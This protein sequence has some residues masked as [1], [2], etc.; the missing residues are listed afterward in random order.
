MKWYNEPR[1]KLIST[2]FWQK[3]KINGPKDQGKLS[4]AT[5]LMFTRLA[6]PKKGNK[7]LNDIKDKGYTKND[8]SKEIRDIY[9]FQSFTDTMK[10]LVKYNIP[11]S[12]MLMY[13]EMQSL[14]QYLFHETACDLGL[15]F[16]HNTWDILCWF[17]DEHNSGFSPHRDRQPMNI[18][19]SFT[20]DQIP[21]YITVWLSLGNSTTENSC[22]YFIPKTIDPGYFDGDID[23]ID[24]L[25]RALKTKEDYL[26]ITA[27]PLNVGE[28]VLFSH[29]CIHWGSKS[30]SSKNPRCS[31]AFSLS[32]NDFEPSYINIDY[33]NDSKQ[34][35]RS[36]LFSLLCGQMICYQDRFQFPLDELKAYYKFFLHEIDSFDATYKA[37]VAKEY[38][39]WYNND[40]EDD[41]QNDDDELENALEAMLDHEL[42]KRKLDEII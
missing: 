4:E 27:M 33:S 17:I 12:F 29:R 37:K 23:S 9:D 11:P 2:E 6:A 34:V 21:K 42:K 16:H 18:S 31:L 3:F 36:K 1:E 38:L 26:E 5:R 13:D 20:K 40:Q 10:E 39:T 41:E 24:P 8:N 22:L 15:K 19:S 35:I 28:R 14:V 32:T 7:F 25:N 30:Q